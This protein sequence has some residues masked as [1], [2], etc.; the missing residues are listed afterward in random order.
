MG[1]R[2]HCDVIYMHRSA[3]FCMLEHTVGRL[4]GRYTFLILGV[5][6]TT[7]SWISPAHYRFHVSKHGMQCVCAKISDII[8]QYAHVQLYDSDLPCSNLH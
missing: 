7:P 5:P 8:S 4:H 6:L 2:H 3:L 1:Q